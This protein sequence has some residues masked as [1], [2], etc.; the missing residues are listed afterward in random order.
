MT[1]CIIHIIICTKWQAQQ[2][3]V[4]SEQQEIAGRKENSAINMQMKG[5]EKNDLFI[6][7]CPK[8]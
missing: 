7:I 5:E 6:S 2:L 3:L 8:C 1:G 4:T